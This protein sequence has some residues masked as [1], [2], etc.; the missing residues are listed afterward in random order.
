MPPATAVRPC[1]IINHINNVAGIYGKYRT[2]HHCYRSHYSNYY[3]YSGDR[4]RHRYYRYYCEAE[5]ATGVADQELNDN[6]TR[7]LLLTD[8]IGPDSML[9]SFGTSSLSKYISWARTRWS[10]HCTLMHQPGKKCPRCPFAKADKLI[11]NFKQRTTSFVLLRYWRCPSLLNINTDD[12][13]V[14]GAGASK[15]PSRQVQRCR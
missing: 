14:H 4:H 3:G 12:A 1:G 13:N 7:I 10:L 8:A 11:S 15:S 2:N 6:T 5:I 9:A